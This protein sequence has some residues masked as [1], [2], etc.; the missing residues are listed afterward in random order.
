[1]NLKQRESSAKYLYDISKGILL[2]GVIGIF[3]DKI[4]VLFFLGHIALA[5]YT[6]FAAY[7]LEGRQ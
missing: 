1:M 4:G 2:A 3:A 7:W 6:F 5:I